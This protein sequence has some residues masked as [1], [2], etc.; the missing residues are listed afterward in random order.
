MMVQWGVDIYKCCMRQYILVSQAQTSYC[1]HSVPW[2]LCVHVCIYNE[3]CYHRHRV[4]CFKGL[5]RILN[6]RLFTLYWLC[7][8][9]HAKIHVM[10]VGLTFQYLCFIILHCKILEAIL[11]VI[12]LCI[13]LRTSD[14]GMWW[15]CT[16]IAFG[17]KAV[18]VSNRKVMYVHAYTNCRYTELSLGTY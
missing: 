18:Y 1:W 8:H 9:C 7:F 16:C 2:V 11:D 15:I 14:S 4:V 3:R 17:L 6:G 5:P 13:V 10:I 12:I